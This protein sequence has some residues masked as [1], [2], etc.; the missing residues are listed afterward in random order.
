LVISHLPELRDFFP[1]RVEVFRDGDGT[2]RFRVV[3]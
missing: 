2:S 3:T 1:Y